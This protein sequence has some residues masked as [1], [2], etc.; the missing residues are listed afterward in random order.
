MDPNGSMPT[1]N[2]AASNSSRE[3][4]I[5]IPPPN[6]LTAIRSTY[7]NLFN[8]ILDSSFNINC[9]C[10]TTYRMNTNSSSSEA[11]SFLV[12]KN[13]CNIFDRANNDFMS[14]DE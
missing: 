11:S 13:T 12:E 14:D 4:P 7:M 2:D 8:Q 1:Q 10:K 9:I 3:I 5:S 6:T